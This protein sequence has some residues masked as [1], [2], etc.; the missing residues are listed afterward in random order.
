MNR[1]VLINSLLAQYQQERTAALRAADQRRRIIAEKAPMYANLETRLRQAIRES[2]MNIGADPD[3]GR[4]A[5]YAMKKEAETQLLESGFSPDDLKPRFKCEEC[6]DTGFIGEPVKEYCRC[7]EKRL[8]LLQMNDEDLKISPSHRFENFDAYLFPEDFDGEP[9]R[10]HMQLAGQWAQK[11]AD[12]F[13]Y[14]ELRSIVFSGQSGLG[15]TF[16]LDSITRRIVE[17]GFSAMRLSAYRLNELMRL[18]HFNGNATDQRFDLCLEVDFL[19]IDDL[20]SE[21]MLENITI[22]YLYILISERQRK[23]KPFIISTNL[24]MNQL[25][26]RYT[27]RFFSRIASK[28]NMIVSL[29]G[30]DIR[31]RI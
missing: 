17:R 5:I 25:K 24:S 29:K 6:E 30:K 19:A 11:Y 7:F 4:K 16:L 13:S 1:S 23:G 22:E 12:G 21:P 15:K 31:L 10:K 27:E 8:N 18:K 9:Q 26:S 20:G 28:K 2:M 3:A 14:D